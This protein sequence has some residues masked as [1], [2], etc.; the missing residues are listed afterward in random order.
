MDLLLVILPVLAVGGLVVALV[1]GLVRGPRRAMRSEQTGEPMRPLG[2][3]AGIYA[4]FFM[5]S[6]VFLVWRVKDGF[7]GLGQNGEACVDTGIANPPVRAEL[8][9]PL[10]GTSV[11]SAGDLQACVAHPAAGQWMLYVLTWLP[12]LLLWGSV[13]LLII[14]LVRHAAQYGPF[15]TR[16]AILMVRLGWLIIAGSA[17]VGALAVLGGS[18]LANMVITPRPFDTGT[19]AFT[20]LMQ[21]SLRALLPVPALAGAAL[22]SF[23]RMTRAGSAMDEELRATV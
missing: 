21:G 16:S 20:V 4:G 10:P 1:Y 23:G 8:W 14:R 11:G 22:L 12:G 9:H 17:V 19:V 5:L 2:N 13:L 6:G 15:T 7:S 3:V 18:V